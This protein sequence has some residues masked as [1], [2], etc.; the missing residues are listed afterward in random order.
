MIGCVVFLRD[1][2]KNKTESTNQKQQS[3][4]STQPSISRQ[5]N[6]KQSSPKPKTTGA[7]IEKQLFKFLES[8]PIDTVSPK[9]IE[10]ARAMINPTENYKKGLFHTYDIE[11]LPR[12][13]NTAG[14]KI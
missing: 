1:L 10:W 7:K 2:R 11:G 4:Q 3:T 8:M 5:N 12:T 14:R 13:N 6:Q 9:A